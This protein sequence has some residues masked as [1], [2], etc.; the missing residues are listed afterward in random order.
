L[1]SQAESRR[2][3]DRRQKHAEGKRKETKENSGYQKSSQG[4]EEAAP[5]QNQQV[6]Q[7]EKRGKETDYIS[8][9]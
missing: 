3:S 2:T 1:I 8:V 4:D 7:P 9:S 6:G 5:K